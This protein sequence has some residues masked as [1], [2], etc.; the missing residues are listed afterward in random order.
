[1]SKFKPEHA[2]LTREQQLLVLDNQRFS[3][4][5]TRRLG[6]KYRGLIAR[7]D[8]QQLVE[9]GLSESARAWRATEGTPFTH[10]A[11]KRIIGAVTR[12]A[13]DEVRQRSAV[14]R[15]TAAC[16]DMQDEQVDIE[17]T[18][19]MLA[20]RAD[21][22]SSRVAMA[23]VLGL[24]TQASGDAAVGPESAL[25]ESD[26]A[27]KARASLRAAVDT[28]P[29]RRRRLVEMYYFEG[30]E[31]RDVAETMSLGYSTV[32]RE[33]NEALDALRSHLRDAGITA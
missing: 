31:L 13:R 29:E 18:T 33:H 26:F 24:A 7:D 28:L 1:M 15:A 20:A 6:A 14:R 19:E 5:M 2:P 8:V 11:W 21:T 17:D 22:L 23:M 25:V 16:L 12:A 30:F 4:T 10:F 32:R 3:H 9:T 27:T